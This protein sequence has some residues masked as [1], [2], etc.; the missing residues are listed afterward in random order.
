MAR[1]VPNFCD[2]ATPSA[3]ERKI[4]D[5][6]KSDPVTADWI[7]LHSLGLARRGIKAYGEVDFVV[8]IPGAGVF[9]LEI[10]GGR[11]ACINGVWETVDRNGVVHPLSRSPFIQAREGMFAVRDDIRARAPTGFPVGIVFGYAVVMPDV[12]FTVACPEWEPWQIFDRETL[13]HPISTALQRLASQ[14]RKMLPIAP[15]GEPSP[16]TL[17]YIQQLLR[18]NFEAIMT[19]GAQIDETELQ[20][21]RL[22]DE[23]FERL[24]NL[25]ENPRCLFEGAAGTG[26]T[27]LAVEYARRSAAEGKRTLLICFNRLLGDWLQRRAVDF[28]LGQVLTA[29]SFF[30][31]VRETITKS[32]FEVDFLREERQGLSDK[33]FREVYPYYGQLAIEERDQ[34][35]DVLVM[36]EAQD[37]LQPGVIAILNVWLKGGLANGQWA[38][39]GDFHR[40]AVY[41]ASSPEEMK[42]LLTKA[43]PALARGRLRMNC[44]NTRNIGEETALLSGF[45]SPPYRLSQFAGIPVDYQYYRAAD[46]QRAKLADVLRRLLSGGVKAQDIIILS[47]SRLTNS[48]VAGLDGGADFKLVEVDDTLPVRSRVPLI[49]FATVQAFKGMESQVIVLCDVEH[50]THGEPQSLLYVAMSRARGHLTVF[51]NEQTR[52]HMKERIRMKLNENW[53]KTP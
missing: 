17:K 13:V 33:L 34:P 26:K 15:A 12:A 50:I 35:F 1:M 36:D 8:L 20:L 24:D 46:E 31:Q 52:P 27:M 4:F 47:Q 22:T 53:S 37:L 18:P 45:D 38:I 7:V 19:C 41:N 3:A 51:L 48:G 40:Q 5:L 21:L 42:A 11:I 9:C 29:G 49:R 44:R 32:S 2:P 25:A 16:S 30:R 39:F 10:K 43:A 28:G 6:L 14:Q 23:Q